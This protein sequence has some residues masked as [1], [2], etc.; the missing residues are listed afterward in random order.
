M[1]ESLESLRRSF[2][3]SLRVEGKADRT[4]VLYGQSIIYFSAWLEQQGHT[5]DLSNLTRTNVLKWL[6][7]LH[8]RGLT[9]GTIRTRWR[10]LRPF[11][12]WLVAEQL[13]HP[14]W[15]ASGHLRRGLRGARPPAAATRCR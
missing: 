12:N 9:D 4:L 3:R 15:S 7:S 6:D 5:A 13:I 8:E 1:A 10:R 2:N 14:R 11:T